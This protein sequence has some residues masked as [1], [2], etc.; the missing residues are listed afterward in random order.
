M[1]RL[2]TGNMHI[3]AL[4]LAALAVITR[5]AAAHPAYRYLPGDEEWPAPAAWNRLNETVQG[6]LIRGL[7]LAHGCFVQESSNSSDRAEDAVCVA[8]QENWDVVEP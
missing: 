6:R 8:L 4:L 5:T 2:F 3:E 7:P 1:M